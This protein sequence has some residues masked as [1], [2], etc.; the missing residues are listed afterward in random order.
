MRTAQ[1]LEP[2]YLKEVAST[3]NRD[4]LL[5]QARDVTLLDPPSHCFYAGQKHAYMN[6]EL[7][8]QWLQ[9]VVIPYRNEVIRCKGLR[10]WQPVAILLDRYC[11]H[12]SKEA[13]DFAR[14]HDIRL[15]CIPAG[16]TDLLQPADTG[17]NKEL[18]RI[19]DEIRRFAHRSQNRFA[20]KDTKTAHSVL[21]NAEHKA[22]RQVTAIGF[23]T[24]SSVS[25]STQLRSL[26]IEHKVPVKSHFLQDRGGIV[27]KHDLL[28]LLFIFAFQT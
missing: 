3:V 11:A 7:M 9:L 20:V 19:L 25:S 17:A 4:D 10:G 22:M 15:I 24:H 1:K 12:L 18:K 27:F 8:L 23:G 21:L 14:L 6:T 13:L 5:Q 16:L 28:L 26:L 2:Q